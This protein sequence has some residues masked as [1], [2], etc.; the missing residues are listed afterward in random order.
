M[1]V[2]IA[3]VSASI[4]GGNQDGSAKELAKEPIPAKKQGAEWSLENLFY[5]NAREKDYHHVQ[6]ASNP[7][8]Y[9]IDNYCKYVP[10]QGWNAES[11]FKDKF[12]EKH[13]GT[14]QLLT[15]EM[16]GVTYVTFKCKMWMTTS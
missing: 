10:V 6:V 14:N 16:I 8:F 2:A 3:L 15:R 9:T 7:S 5:S 4:P 13:T 1:H 11:S 12:F